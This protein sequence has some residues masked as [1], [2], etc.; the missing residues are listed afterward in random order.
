M[1]LTHDFIARE[2]KGEIEYSFFFSCKSF[3]SSL[4]ACK[5]ANIAYRKS[6]GKVILILIFFL[7]TLASLVQTTGTKVQILTL[8]T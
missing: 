7:S 2:K 3:Y 1:Y 4:Q 8:L 6:G 5:C